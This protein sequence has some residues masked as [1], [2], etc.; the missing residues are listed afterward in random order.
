M[1]TKNQFIMLKDGAKALGK[2]CQHNCESCFLD[3]RLDGESC[4]PVSHIRSITEDLTDELLEKA[5][6]ELP[7]SI[8]VEKNDNPTKC[9]DCGYYHGPRGMNR[10]DMEVGACYAKKGAPLVEK[11]QNSC[12]SF[13][14]KNE[15]EVPE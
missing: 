14:R 4:C 6:Q 9:G 8:A 11:E 12:A 2:L 5:I 7:D 15:S 13:D 10:F 3:K 1:P